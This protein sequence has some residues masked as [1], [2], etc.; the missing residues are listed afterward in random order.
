[1][2][3]LVG[4]VAVS[5]VLNQIVRTIENHVTA[6]DWAWVSERADMYFL[7]VAD[8]RGFP[9][10]SASVG[11]AFPLALELRIVGAVRR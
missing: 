10:E 3:S 5:S 8:E 2:T 4:I 11:T 1:M 7:D 6:L 9:L